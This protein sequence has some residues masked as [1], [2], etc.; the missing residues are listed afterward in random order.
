MVHT[1][2]SSEEKIFIEG[3][4]GQLET[5]V[6]GLDNIQEL[7]ENSIKKDDSTL[8]S[9]S[10]I[11]TIGVVCHPH[12]LH[13]G[14]MNNKVVTMICKALQ[15][16]GLPTVRFNFRGVGESEG[17]YDNGTGERLDLEAVLS[18][19]QK[20]FPDAQFCLA[21]F[22]FGSYIALQVAAE[23]QSF[24]IKALLS[25]APPVHH[26]AFD[27]LLLPASPWVII[28]GTE[29][30]IVSYEKVLNWVKVLEA[31]KSNLQFITMEGAEHFFH[32]KLIELKTLIQESFRNS[33]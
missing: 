7:M 15:S 33:L 19:L 22:S 9:I 8:S 11:K 32:G 17:H 2:T 20:S 13:Q 6:F 5:M 12:P 1:M 4:A 18:F 21:G 3:P 14:T 24:P 26:F 31:K 23:T 30:S 25:V 10:S 29:D 27:K 28:Q 16:L